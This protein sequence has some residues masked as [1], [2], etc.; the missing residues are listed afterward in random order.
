M[1]N[2]HERTFELDEGR[3]VRLGWRVF[4]ALAV[5]TVVEY[6]VAV[7]LGNNLTPL[8]VIALT[9]AGLIARYFMHIVAL[10]RGGEEAH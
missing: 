7:E 1:E 9:K 3:A 2:E 4:A 6:V 5:L 8:A 10:W